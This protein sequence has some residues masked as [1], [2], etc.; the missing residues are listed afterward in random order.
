MVPAVFACV[1]SCRSLELCCDVGGF[2]EVVEQLVTTK[3][4]LAYCLALRTSVTLCGGAVVFGAFNRGEGSLMTAVGAAQML[5]P[6]HQ[7][8]ECSGQGVIWFAVVRHRD[9]QQFGVGV[10]G[11]LC[12]PVKL[13]GLR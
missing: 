9:E 6:R 10:R 12:Q 13:V 11:V 1:G 2:A 7:V 4:E 3:Q 5:G 8:V